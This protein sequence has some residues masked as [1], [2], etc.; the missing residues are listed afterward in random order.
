MKTQNFLNKSFLFCFVFVA[1][2]KFVFAED[3]IRQDSS[4]YVLDSKHN[5]LIDFE[6]KDQNGFLNV[7]VEIPTGTNEK[8]EVSKNDGKIRWEFKNGKPRI[9]N[10]LGYPGN[11]GMIPKT[12]LPKELG[13]DGDPLD[14]IVL[15]KAVQRGEVV[16]AKLIGVLKMLDRGEKDDKLIAVLKDSPFAKI[17]NLEEL[18]SNFLGVTEIL[19]I[20]FT[21]YKGKVESKGFGSIQEA[22]EI[23]NS[24]LQGFK[25][26]SK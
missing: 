3:I 22:N 17:N 12:L 9:V 2:A 19:E 15:G 13:G 26:N 21:N 14:V 25:A 6:P 20:W 4:L 23:L 11:Y 1:F 7:V 8:W 24:A 18:K 5:F 16:K 10:F